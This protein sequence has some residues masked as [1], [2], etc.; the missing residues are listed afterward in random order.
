MTDE[1]LLPD[2]SAPRPF[3][4]ASPDVGADNWPL[5]VETCARYL[6]PAAFAKVNDAYA[7]AAEMHANQRRRSGEAYI[8]HPVEVALILA[9]DLHMD[10]DVICAALLHDTVEDTSTSLEDVSGRFGQTVAELVDGVTKLTSI[11]VDSMDAKQA[12]NLRKMFLAMSKDMRVVIIKLADRLHNMRTLAALS[13]TGASSRR[14]RPWTSTRPSPTASASPR[15]SGS[16]RT[17]RSSTSSRRSTSASRAWS[18][19]RASSASVTP[20]RPS[21]PSTTSSGMPASPATR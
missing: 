16:S 6:S 18:R 12:L 7:F 13:P 9:H 21:R 3:E 8:N 19:T 4:P 14:A 17:S 1:M 5:L 20:T 10:E 11:E 15:S 2:D